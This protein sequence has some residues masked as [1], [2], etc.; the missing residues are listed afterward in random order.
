VNLP[1]KIRP[2]H[3]LKSRPRKKGRADVKGQRM[4]W[5]HAQL[6][7]DTVIARTWSGLHRRLY[8]W[9]TLV[10]RA[11]LPLTLISFRLTRWDGS[12]PQV[13]TAE[14]IRTYLEHNTHV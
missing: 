11:G 3:A 7:L 6:G 12:Q 9:R 5:Y 14:H 10:R 8:K 13:P 2:Q 1:L 4:V